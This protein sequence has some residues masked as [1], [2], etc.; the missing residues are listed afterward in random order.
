MNEKLLEYL[1]SLSA[2]EA[3]R[4]SDSIDRRARP[5]AK[6]FWSRVSSFKRAGWNDSIALRMADEAMS[7]EDPVKQLST[8][9]VPKELFKVPKTAKTSTGGGMGKYSFDRDMSDP[10]KRRERTSMTGGMGRYSFDRENYSVPSPEDLPLPSET[11]KPNTGSQ[12]RDN[13]YDPINVGFKGERAS[14]GSQNT[15]GGNSGVKAT[16]RTREDIDNLPNAEARDPNVTDLDFLKNSGFESL[17]KAASDWE[18]LKQGNA[19]KYAQDGLARRE[20]L[21]Y[22]LQDA[23]DV[24]GPLVSVFD[25]LEQ[26]REEKQAFNIADRSMRQAPSA[27]AVR[28]ENRILSNLI[29]NSQIAYSNPQQMI[30]PYMDQVNLGYQQDLAQ[31]Q[32]LSG[33]QAGNAVGLSQA[34][35]IRR[36]RANQ[37]G[38]RMSSDIFREGLATTGALVGQQMQD[39]TWR[40]QQN[41]ELY[42]IANANNQELQRQAGVGLA[43]SRARSLQARNNMLDS[44][45]N[46]PVF[47]VDTYMGYTRNNLIN[48]PT[49]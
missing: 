37:E 45:L 35:S 16:S 22:F 33:G 1:N 15:S 32:Q 28:G 43:S 31:A 25:F 23:Q 9:S 49:I 10:T 34:A 12:R 26:R 40:D 8:G 5:E 18:V 39:D 19:D 14:K 48:P 2:K 44:M 29:R 20:K 3:K 30:Q 7:F 36:N 4:I 46:S 13:Y 38:M 27:P 21:N 6:F 17:K 42:R 47:D 11:Y 41:I 24:V